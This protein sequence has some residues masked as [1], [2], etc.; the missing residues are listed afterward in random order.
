MARVEVNTDQTTGVALLQIKNQQDYHTI[1]SID[2]VC[3]HSM[4][5]MHHYITTS[6]IIYQKI[7]FLE[8]SSM[9][10]MLTKMQNNTIDKDIHQVHVY[11]EITMERQCS[12]KKKKQKKNC[13]LNL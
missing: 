8:C 2:S 5:V 1:T 4:T 13:R 11:I 12:E 6:T 7:A 9:C 3:N 10:E